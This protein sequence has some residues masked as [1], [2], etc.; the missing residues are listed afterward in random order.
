MQV[1]DTATGLCEG[2]YEVMIADD[3]QD[4]IYQTVVIS[5]PPEVNI[6]ASTDTMICYGQSTEL[7]VS[8]ASTYVWDNSAGTGDSV[9]VSPSAT[10]TYTVI[11]T[12]GNS[13]SDTAQVTITVNPLPDVTI[14]Q[15]GITLIAQNVGAGITYQWVDCNNSFETLSGETNQSFT[16]SINGSYA[17][18]IND[19][20]CVDTSACAVITSVGI[21]ENSYGD[22]YIIYPNPTDGDFSID[23]GE[24]SNS[25]LLTMTDLIG[26]VIQSKNY[27][28]VQLLNLNI[29]EPAGIYLLTIESGDKKAVIRLVKE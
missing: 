3:A 27:H 8:G 22:T 23:L 20:G 1:N 12:D 6:I 11:G 5:S 18:I 9:L 28:D 2:T 26:N 14:D 7:T 25:V 15:T 29:E 4:T 21:L 24:N 19:N 13:C 10:T 16:A 17:V